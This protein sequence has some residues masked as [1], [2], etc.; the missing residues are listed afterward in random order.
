VRARSVPPLV[1]L[2]LVLLTV[3]V[4]GC[5]L[6]AAL[7]THPGATSVFGDWASEVV[8][9]TAALLCA[10]VA[11]RLTRPARLAW[12]L[13]AAGIVVWT[14]G[15][16]YWITV[17]NADDSP[18]IPSPADAAYLLFAPLVFAGLIVLLHAR[19]R[20]VPRTVVI[21]G[22]I[23]A[24][25]AATVSAAF[26]LQP[27]AAHATGSL[28]PVA[29]N[30]AYPVTDV[31]L[32]SVVLAA[33]ALRRWRL[34]RTWGLLGAGILTFFVADGLYLVQTAN[35]TY[36]EPS[37]YAVGWPASTVLFAWAAWAPAEVR[38]SAQ[39]MASTRDI[40]L[41]L[42]LAFAA[43][44]V[45][46]LQPPDAGHAATIALG[47]ACAAAVM[48]R[49]IMTFRE[50]AAMVR[51]SRH[52]AL[53]DALTGLG[54]RRALTAD[55]DRR[56]V[57]A[58]DG[59]PLVLVL[60]DLDGFKN[61]ND[62]F[63]HPAGD[64]LLARLGQN[65]A[66]TV[67]GRG[68]A[69]RMGGDEFCALISPGSEVSRPIVEAAARALG[70]QG[71]GFDIGCSFGMATLPREAADAEEAMRVVDQRMYA[72]KQGG[73]IS[74]GRQTTEVLLR[75][76]CERDARLGTHVIDVAALAEGVAQRLGLGP[77]E[78]TA[79]RDAAALHDIGKMAIPDAILDKPG[80]LD[81]RERAFIR[82]HTLIGE[83]I[84]AAAP[85]LGTVAGLVRSSHERFDGAGYPDGI[86][87]TEIPL[88]SRI[89]AVCD[90]FDAMITD[91]SYRRAIEP[92]AALH[93][94]RGCAGSQFDP[95]IVEAFCE[96][97]TQVARR[98]SAPVG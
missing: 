52:E 51:A 53:T 85:S 26:V 31:A 27:V 80:P 17:L 3:W 70:E 78:V 67:V 77:T 95:V 90:A 40:V 59:A 86:A 62:R 4:V 56:L 82:E 24:L 28:L 93:E 20:D 89:V 55:L 69:Y 74:A 43:L 1:R 11:R 68:A 41:P 8:Q 61:Y 14:L 25:A 38:V 39:R 48:A 81:E 2:I 92:V 36:T 46:I 32:L 49:L 54:N 91:R 58:H 29:T 18:P 15:D 16:V 71:E 60:F 35:G 33:V 97:W 84:L 88:G 96:E 5:E 19:M 34:D 66:R 73:R 98:R 75:A 13:I 94:L 7:P 21:D 63:G 30:L 44:V 23:V 42:L 76:M 37:L 50:N 6:S 65:L 9:L 72:A 57:E 64:A 47:L 87:G 45:S 10:A 12:G 83:R 79:V 22:I